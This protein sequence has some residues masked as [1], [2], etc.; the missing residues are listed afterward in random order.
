VTDELDRMPE[1]GDE[2][3]IKDGTLRVERVVGN[4]LERLKFT[5]EELSGDTIPE[6]A[7]DLAKER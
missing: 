1:L 3:R 4:H 7:D 2:I 5:P 6:S